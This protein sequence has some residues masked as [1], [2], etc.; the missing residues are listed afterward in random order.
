[1][2]RFDRIFLL[3]N[4]LQNSRRPVS[5]KQLQERLECS[6]ATVTRTIE[7]LRDYL[8]APIEYNRK[9][10]GYFYN[11]Q[12]GEMFELPGLWFNATELQALLGMQQL[13]ADLQ[14][15]LLGHSLEPLRKRLDEILGH[16]HV[17]GDELVR[18]I[19]I[20]R[21]AARPVGEQFQNVASCLAGRKRLQIDY[22]NRSED[23][24]TQREVSPQRLTHYRDNWYLDGWCHLRSGLRT[25]ALDAISGVVALDEEALEVSDSELD[26]HFASAYG[27]FAGRA[28]KS[29]LLLFSPERARWVSREQWHPEQQGRM[30]EDGSYELCIP[31]SQPS[32]LIMDILK[33]GPDV[34]VLAPEGLRREV[35]QRLQ[36]AAGRYDQ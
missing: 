26:E 12:A 3:N 2:D 36:A 35:R 29:A 24:T 28:D 34:E 32:E 6:R 1:M 9:A 19:R 4:I 11:Q 20:L 14:P 27:I 8:N 23:T 5:H 31:Y 21:M 10:N 7:D 15:G 17:G 25:F 22:Y 33:Y 18:R 13:L 16:Q 30:L